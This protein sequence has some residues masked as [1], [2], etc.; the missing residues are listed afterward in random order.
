M[1]FKKIIKKSGLINTLYFSIA[2]K[3]AI[4]IISQ[5]DEWL[6]M[7][8][9][10]LSNLLNY[11]QKHSKYYW[12][13]IGDQKVTPDTAVSVLKTL[14]LLSKDIIREREFSIYSDEIN[15][16]WKTWANTGG[17][18][19]EPL[20]FPR[21]NGNPMCEAI[22][23]WI[24]YNYLNQQG[25]NFSDTIVSFGGNRLSKDKVENK[26]F[27]DISGNFP[28]GKYQ[29][30]TLY[31][32][33]ENMPY[34]VE[35]LNDTRASYI[36]GYSSS[37]LSIAQYIQKHKI[38]IKV[39]LKGIYLT[40]EA[41]QESSREFIS[42]VFNCPVIGQYGHTEMSVYA[43]QHI[44]D[45][46]YECL[47][48]YGYTEILNELGQHVK[49]GE[50]GEIVVTGFNQVGLPFI[51]YK[52]GDIAKY[53]GTME[54]GTVLIDA[55]QGRT[56]DYLYDTDGKKVFLTA[57]IFGGHIKAFNY[58]NQWQLVQ[59]EYG[60]VEV[61]IIKGDNYNKNTEICLQLF[62]KSFKIEPTFNYVNFIKKQKNGKQK[63]LIQ[64]II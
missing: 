61:Y 8:S 38:D 10:Y 16:R 36:R 29:F 44:E 1:K 37:I 6:N 35:E 15:K 32:T 30:S 5:R 54:D 31:M 20:K 46:L 3:R 7:Q 24:T 14:P 12:M 17:S 19:G 21:K 50:S 47:P 9:R 57:M 45:S 63:F 64:K 60:K 51:R 59:E 27:Y 25:V 33:D 62:F 22:C 13:H 23:Q 40:S 42:K 18:T 56:V 4:A 41:F 34:Y 2:S 52:T 43:Y 55:I 26:V 11:A 48:I 49:E 53:C 28:W 39:K 58:I